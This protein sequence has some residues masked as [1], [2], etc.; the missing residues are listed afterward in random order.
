VCESGLNPG[1]LGSH[2]DLVVNRLSAFNLLNNCMLKYCTAIT[3][4]LTLWCLSIIVSVTV[5]GQ[6][7]IFV[8]PINRGFTSMSEFV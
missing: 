2:L 7:P 5:V 3:R 1:R 6:Q 8:H 4:C